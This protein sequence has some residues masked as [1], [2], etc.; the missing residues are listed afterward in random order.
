MPGVGPIYDHTSWNTY[1]QELG[2]A[3]DLL[4]PNENPDNENTNA[5]YTVMSYVEHPSEAGEDL[6][7]QGFALTPM[8]WD[9]QAMQELY[10]ADTTTR[11]TDTVYFGDGGSTSGVLKYQYATNANNDLG[12]QVRGTDGNYRGVYLTICAG[13]DILSGRSGADTVRDFNT[14]QSGEVIDLSDVAAITN[15]SD[16]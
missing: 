15:F 12:M 2:H 3:L 4:H 9:I 5:Q 7:V 1:L 14:G 8:V 16:L 13:N 11:A 6:I 10:G